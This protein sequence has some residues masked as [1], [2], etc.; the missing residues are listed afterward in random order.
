M[1]SVTILIT[2]KLPVCVFVLSKMV[3]LSKRAQA[4]DL[5]ASGFCQNRAFEF[6]WRVRPFC[7]TPDLRESRPPGQPPDWLESV[8]V[9]IS[10]HKQC[11]ISVRG[12]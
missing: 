9:F 1:D 4:F 3:W 10:T 5:G 8:F 6:D 12:S 11:L 7:Q 2:C